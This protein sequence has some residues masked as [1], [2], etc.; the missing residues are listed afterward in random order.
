MKPFMATIGKDDKFGPDHTIPVRRIT[1]TPELVAVHRNILAVFQSFPHDAKYRM[2]FKPH[3]TIAK[4]DP[5]AQA[6]DMIEVGGFSIAEKAPRSD[7]WQIVAKIGLKGADIA[8]DARIIKYSER[9][10][11]YL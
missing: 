8:T 2:P 3:I 5:R 7:T 6:K 1:R 10:K 9:N 11:E 4:D